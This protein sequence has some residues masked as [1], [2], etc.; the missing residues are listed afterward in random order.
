MGTSVLVERG[1]LLPRG[2]MALHGI[3]KTEEA[4][5]SDSLWQERAGNSE[6]INA[7]RWQDGRSDADAGRFCLNPLLLRRCRLDRQQ[8]YAEIQWHQFVRCHGSD[9]ET[10]QL[11]VAS[12][13]LEN[14][15]A[16]AV[17]GGQSGQVKKTSDIAL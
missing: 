12:P 3:K 1:I 16:G 17:T 7:T 6:S 4:A 2:V 10:L 11:T 14:F 8:R 5:Q 13:S 15:V 9:G